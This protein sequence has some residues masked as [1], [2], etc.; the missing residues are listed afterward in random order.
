MGLNSSSNKN[1]YS[2]KQT[3]ELA[4]TQYLSDLDGEIPSNLYDKVLSEIEKPLFS[5][6]MDHCENNQSK[7]ASCL[8]IN[9]GTLRKKLKQYEIN[10]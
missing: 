1:N 5:T 6:I 3:V 2:L 4:L 8:G 7:A 9:R 10:P